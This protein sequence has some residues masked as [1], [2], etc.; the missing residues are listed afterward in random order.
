[1]ASRGRCIVLVSNILI[2]ESAIPSDK[3]VC[4]GT[5]RHRTDFTY[6]NTITPNDIIRGCTQAFVHSLG[7]ESRSMNMAIHG[8]PPFGSV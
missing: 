7:M 5:S 4:L 1:M 8:E 3:V 6:R 2:G